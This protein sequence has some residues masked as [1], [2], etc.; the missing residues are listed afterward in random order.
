MPTFVDKIAKHLETGKIEQALA[1]AIGAWHERRAIAIA[2]LVDEIDAIDQAP[3]FEGSTS[4]WTAA[5]RKA[6]T[7]RERGALL[8]SIAKRPSGDLSAAMRIASKWEDPRLSTQI[9]ALLTALPFS[10]K[11]TR[12]VWRDVIAIAGEQNDPRFLVLFDTLPTT[13]N[14]GVDTKR[15]LTNRLGEAIEGV[16][17]VELDAG[18]EAAVRALAAKTKPH[19]Q[20]TPQNATSLL[21]AIYANPDDDGP[22]LVYA[23][24]L[25]ERGDPHG[26]FIALQLQA[27]PDAAA[28]KRMRE[29]V[30][31]HKKAWLG[32]LP[33][34]GDIEFRRGFPAKGVVK[35]RNQRDAEQ[36][37]SNPAWATLEELE[38]RSGTARDDQIEWAHYI[39]PAM[40]GLRFADEA[41][42]R[43]LLAAT[44]PW[45]IEHLALPR[46]IEPDDV[47]KI[48]ESTVF[49]H[50]KILE[51]PKQDPTLIAGVLRSPPELR[52]HASFESGLPWL[53][54]ARR[55]PTL[56]RFTILYSI[57]ELRF[58]RDRDGAFTRLD[59][60][61][62][63]PDPIAAPADF[64]RGIDNTAKTIGEL[65]AK[66]LT[67]FAARIRAGGELVPLPS[68]DKVG[69]TKLRSD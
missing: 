68:V 52:I 2:E 12:D 26:E 25:Q 19:A 59:V 28:T 23:D 40:T 5:A 62:H 13:W 31:K 10:G 51:I 66:L 38:W 18:V 69:A 60:E 21:D 3:A 24:W 45:R 43:S 20:A 29:L 64:Q 65:P 30:K 61:L 41:H 27:S 7:Q 11:R 46:A 49:P 56:E 16:A 6:T 1:V 42:P 17:T 44:M 14:V 37:G 22:R 36:H 33:L 39:S 67:H 48:C 35:F 63:P 32:T 54:N 4:G 57:L 15:F 9:I 8:R 50:L 34:G 53:D 55:I 47:K 58:S